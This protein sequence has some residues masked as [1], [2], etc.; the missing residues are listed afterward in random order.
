[1]V[2]IK[3]YDDEVTC[4]VYIPDLQ[5]FVKETNEHLVRR[6]TKLQ[7]IPNEYCSEFKLQLVDLISGDILS[8]IILT[9]PDIDY[10]DY[11]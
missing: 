5:K 6:R 8:T 1:M 7:V 10:P 2:N 11:W 4:D 9:E 3:G